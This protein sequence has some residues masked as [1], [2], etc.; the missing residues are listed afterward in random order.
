MGYYLVGDRRK[1]VLQV[2][3]YKQTS[4]HGSEIVLQVFIYKRTSSHGSDYYL[5]SP[6]EIQSTVLGQDSVS[7]VGFYWIGVTDLP[8]SCK[9][10]F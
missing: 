3:I 7:V 6:L 5:Y 8:L 2:F 4:S 10:L 1:I 9:M